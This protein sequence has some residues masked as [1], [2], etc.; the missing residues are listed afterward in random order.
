MEQRTILWAVDPFARAKSLQRSA[1]KA[2]LALSQTLVGTRARIVPVYLLDSFPLSIPKAAAD[3]YR[4]DLIEDAHAKL[5][6]IVGR[7]ASPFLRQLQVLPSSMG[8]LQQ[9]AE[10]LVQY[11]EKTRAKLIVLS[12]HARRGVDRLFMGS[13]A[14]TL[15][16]VS[17]VPVMVV[18]PSWRPK[19]KR[20]RRV[21]FPTDFS[22]A[23]R[24]AFDELLRSVSGESTEIIL[25]HKVKYDFRN[26][27][28]RA[29]RE[30]LK[31]YMNQA[32]DRYL[33]SLRDEAESWRSSALRKGISLSVVMDYRFS[34]NVADAILAAA[35][36]KGVDWIAT[37]ATSGV[38]K[39]KL[40][41]S[42][43]RRIVRESPCPVWILRPEARQKARR[44]DS[45]QAA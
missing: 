35:E 7:D 39:T 37:A 45:G 25:F 9:G 26:V 3:D 28:E 17:P 16:L 40:L 44:A 22:D 23:S 13:F 27:V 11:A 20:C 8:P 24:L 41:G 42:V 14:E 33:E 18:N 10:E 43:T 4:R 31:E 2:A 5:K 1:L 19:G 34:G 38:L 6:D 30:G 29:R 36:R 15:L 12:S 21:L 32:Y